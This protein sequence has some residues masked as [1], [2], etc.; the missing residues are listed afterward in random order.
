MFALVYASR[1]R[2]PFEESD[3]RELESH[4]CS[5][6]E[7]LGITGYLNY[8]KGTFLQYLEGEQA[9]VLDLMNTIEQDER[10]TV[11][12]TVYL[13]EVEER[14][15]ENCY[16]RYWTQNELVEIKVEDLLEEVLLRMN[17]L[18]YGEERLRSF[19]LQLATRIAELHRKYPQTSR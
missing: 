11:V 4:A 18:I 17:E 9:T 7:R 15:F 6:N 10:H 1:A 3:L 5:K 14:R 19:T 12:R 13:P 8:K 2:Q 16:M